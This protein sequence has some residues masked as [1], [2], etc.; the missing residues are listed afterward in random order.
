MLV[1]TRNFLLIKS[2]LEEIA[3]FNEHVPFTSIH[4]VSS[5]GFTTFLGS[6]FLQVAYSIGGIGDET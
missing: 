6:H 2:S 4:S 5:I 1:L 3:K